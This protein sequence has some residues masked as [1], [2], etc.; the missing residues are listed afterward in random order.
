MRSIGARIAVW[1]A[2]AAT[3]TLAIV[4]V[5]GYYY[6]QRNLVQGLDLLV[7]SEFKQIQAHLGPEFTSL[8]AP[9]RELQVREITDNAAALF[10][11][12]V[13]LPDGGV[14]R[15]ANLN[16]SDIP[17]LPAKQEI[18]TVATAVGELRIGSFEMLPFKLI[19]GTPLQPVR[20]VM[21]N[22]GRACI[23]LL[24]LMIGVSLAIGVG[25]GRLVL[26]PVRLIRD[27]ADRIRMDNLHERIPVGEVRDEIADMAR[28]LNQM[29]DRL[30]ASF[31]QI[32]R[33]TAEASHELKTPLSLIR[34]HAEKLL[35][36]PDLDPGQVEALQV[37]LE[38]ISHLHRII[39][40]LL[41]L[42]RA[43]AHAI[44][45]RRETVNV[46]DFLGAFQ[47]D[48][49]ALAE[50]HGLHFEMQHGGENF[51]SFEPKGIRQVLLNLLANA[52]NVSPPD[53]R[54]TLQSSVAQGSWTFTMDDQ[55]PGLPE[56]Q[57]ER[58]F[59][60]FVRHVRAGVD[61]RGSGLGL[62]VC[63]SIVGLHGGSIR[64]EDSPG[65]GLRVRVE[66]PGPKADQ[67]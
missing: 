19:V 59:E 21:T 64:A 58:V 16:D 49:V 34:L 50:H 1:Y 30:E 8:S 13:H 26:R 61:T 51:A 32:R 63:R 23:A 40:D 56:D 45:L 20:E 17:D 47:Q 9:F 6:L 11:I 14:L 5:T 24:T 15:S 48:A 43:D 22:Y 52:I 53:S 44:T 18:G 33:F 54:I 38:E 28:L 12:E 27:T 41:F 42:S 2:S 31:T 60:R 39:E 67:D 46:V 57:R 4:F 3:V 10:Y 25:L 55:G 29:F 37:Q 66:L 65:Q 7:R 62:A 35:G 36:D